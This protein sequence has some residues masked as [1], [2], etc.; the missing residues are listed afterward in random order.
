[1]TSV[2]AAISSEKRSP[3]PAIS[4][5]PPPIHPPATGII[6]RPIS[7]TMPPITTFGKKRI[8]RLIH[9]AQQRIKMPETITEP[10]IAPIPYSLPISTI[11]I[12]AAKVQPWISGRRQ[13]NHCLMPIDCTMVAAPQINKSALIN[14]IICSAGKPTALPTTSG[15]ATAPAYITSTCCN[16]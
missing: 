13:P 2:M 9:G 6:E 3:K 16:P 8:R 7:V 10:E 11:G 4:L 1:M 12:S 5:L 14:K 15:T